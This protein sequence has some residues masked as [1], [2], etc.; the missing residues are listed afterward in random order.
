M[1]E[2]DLNNE[3]INDQEVIQQLKEADHFYICHFNK[4]R[5]KNR[6]PQMFLGREI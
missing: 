6:T 1:L 4:K 2:K 5:D 3:L